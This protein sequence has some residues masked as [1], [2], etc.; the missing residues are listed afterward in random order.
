MGTQNV[1]AGAAACMKMDQKS[2]AQLQMSTNRFVVGL[3]MACHEMFTPKVSGGGGCA[4]F[5]FFREI[6]FIYN[7]LGCK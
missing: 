7:Y 3:L 1:V 2:L 5:D 4:E 6:L